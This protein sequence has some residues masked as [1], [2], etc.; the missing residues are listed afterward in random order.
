MRGTGDQT[1]FGRNFLRC[2]ARPFPVG[3]NRNGFGDRVGTRALDGIPG[4]LFGVLVFPDDVIQV[5]VQIA[6]LRI[7]VMQRLIGGQPRPHQLERPRSTRRRARAVGIGLALHHRVRRPPQ[8]GG[9]VHAALQHAVI[10]RRRPVRGSGAR[11][12]RRQL[13]VIKGHGY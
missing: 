11:I 4:W 6:V 5:L 2:A 1:L 7:V 9:F 12:N 13:G 10:D 8:G 3:P